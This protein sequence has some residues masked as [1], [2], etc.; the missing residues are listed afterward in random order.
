[1]A[2]R[3]Q[4]GHARPPATILIR[5]AED[6]ARAAPSIEGDTGRRAA[7][8]GHLM[9][10]VESRDDEQTAVSDRFMLTYVAGVLVLMV[11][12]LA[13]YGLIALSV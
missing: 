10:G 9:K 1:M 5:V 11:L 4:P 13:G 6:R 7:G 12:N 8:K 2:Q 3:S